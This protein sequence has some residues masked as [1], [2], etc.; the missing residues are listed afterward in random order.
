M[1][2]SKFRFQGTLLV[3]VKNIETSLNFFWAGSLKAENNEVFVIVFKA[4]NKD[5]FVPL[6][7]KDLKILQD[8]EQTD[9]VKQ[10]IAFNE[11]QLS[12]TKNPVSSKCQI[13]KCWTSHR[14]IGFS[15]FEKQQLSGSFYQ[16]KCYLYIWYYCCLLTYVSKKN[17]FAF[18]NAKEFSR[19]LALLSHIIKDGVFVSRIYAAFVRYI[20]VNI[21]DIGTLPSPGVEIANNLSR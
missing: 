5:E 18:D 1:E 4:E 10:Q 20:V 2:T 7:E 8:M 21:N 12:E 19:I 13:N 17:S 15:I 9:S 3:P 14:G 11:K 16:R 6:L